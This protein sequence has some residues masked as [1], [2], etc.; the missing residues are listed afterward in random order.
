LAIV[1]G[2]GTELVVLNELSGQLSWAVPLLIAVGCGSAL[3]LAADLGR[4]ARAIGVAAALALLLAAPTVWAAETLGHAA[5]GTFPT[6]GPASAVGH[7][8]GTRASMR[9][10]APPSFARAGASG[11]ANARLGAPPAS[12]SGGA[13]AGGGPG[14]PGAGGG[15]F[16]RE[17]TTLTAAIRY[18]AAHGGGTIGVSSQSSAAAA[19]ISSNA[20]VAGLGG[21]SGRESSVSAAW[22]AQQVR[23][24]HLRWVLFDSSGGFGAPGDTRAGSRAALSVI[25]KTCRAVTVTTSSGTRITMYD[26]QG[27]AA[28][29]LRGAGSSSS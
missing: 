6:G 17:T 9:F 1:A 23:A 13:G 16:G 3:A 14:G 28:A 12:A 8:P 25:A 10:G 24:G 4:R 27:R 20:S 22:I 19:I 18:A 15:P 7:G 11:A 2:A 21:F 29:I 26:C 5:N